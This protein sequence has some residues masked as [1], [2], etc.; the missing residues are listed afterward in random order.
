M[1]TTKRFT[2]LALSSALVLTTAT[3]C[4]SGPYPRESGPI[5]YTDSARVVS[6]TPV[7]EET[8]RPS[9]ECWREQTGYSTE[10]GDRSYG[11]ALLGGIVGGVVGHQFGKGSGRDAATAAGA[12]IGAITGDNI[13]NRDRSRQVRPVEEERCRTVDHW[14]RRITGYNV[15]YRYQ[16]TDYSTFMPY[17]PGATVRLNVNIS[18][19]DH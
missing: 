1:K 10:P 5:H 8:N 15:I 4:A 7:Y 16:G 12:M 9:R 17:D 6:S 19:V 18:V 14:T 11:G 3:A 13:D 2:A